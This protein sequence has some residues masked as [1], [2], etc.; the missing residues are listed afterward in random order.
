[1]IS[2]TSLLLWSLQQFH[3]I[4]DIETT[5]LWTEKSIGKTTEWYSILRKR[6]ILPIA[7]T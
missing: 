4:Q 3:N 1:M 7:T 6:E 2:E 5:C